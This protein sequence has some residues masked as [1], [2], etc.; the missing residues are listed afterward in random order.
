MKLYLSWIKNNKKWFWYIIPSVIIISLIITTVRINDIEEEKIEGTF[1]DNQIKVQ[2]TIVKSIS[3]N[4]SSEF[5]LIISEMEGLADSEAI[6]KDLGNVDSSKIIEE[7]FNKMNSI[8]PTA[9]ILAVDENSI[10]VSQV[11]HHHTSFVGKKLEGLSSFLNEQKNSLE[12]KPEI[13]TIRS[14]PF[15]EPEIA[16]IKQVVDKQTQ[17]SKGFIM[18]TIP[19]NQ[20]FERHGNIYDIKSQF[21]VALDKNFII[22]VHPQTDLIGQNFYNASIL[23]DI[24]RN[25][26][27]NN[28]YKNVRTGQLTTVILESKNDENE[29]IDSGIPIVVNGE[30]ELL[31]SVITPIKSINK[32]ISD[33]VLADKLQTSLI[34]VVAAGFLAVFLFKFSENFRKEKLVI[35]GQ[36]ASNIAHDMRN[37]L[38]T[39]RSSSQRIQTQNKN[40]NNIIDDE[41]LRINRSIKRMS[42]QVEGVLNYVRTTPIIP[43]KTSVRK[44]LNYSLELVEVPE[45]I[46]VQLPENDVIIEC[47]SEKLEI[48]FVN[49]ILN[50]VQAIGDD[51]GTI[52]IRLMEKSNDIQIDFE[53]SGSPIPEKEISEIFKPLFTTKL[54]GTGLGLSS[55]KNIIEEHKGKIT[56]ISNPVTFTIILPKQVSE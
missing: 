21:L 7:T 5:E 46:K 53:N 2:E 30:I 38:G 15:L 44:M 6:Q 26:I 14:P 16:I 50:A 49:L 55:C 52:T 1:V 34:L 54:K 36:L 23:E 33:I 45:N 25:K 4:I 40:Q 35:I 13:F 39:I 42:H 47:D 27:L 51:Q 3:K 11:S 19:P 22:L 32:E 31:F 24:N 10:V 37:P 8:A 18:V 28:H 43:S 12:T 56:A 17:I 20:F 48:V 29:V 9:Q 41:I